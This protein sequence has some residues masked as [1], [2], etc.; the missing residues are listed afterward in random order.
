MDWN[1]WLNESISG[2][3]TRQTALPRLVSNVLGLLKDEGFVLGCS[4]AAF[5]SQIASVLYEHGGKSS[6]S[7]KLSPHP[8]AGDDWFEDYMV[9]YN[10]RLSH[11]RWEPMWR[12]WSVWKELDLDAQALIEEL[13]WLNVD[14]ANSPTV[15]AFDATFEEDEEYSAVY[16]DE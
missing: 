4:P 15:A 1:D 10:D 8:Y 14:L 7:V 16:V 2:M 5:G 11:L 6:L 12:T 13:A 9:L 3:F